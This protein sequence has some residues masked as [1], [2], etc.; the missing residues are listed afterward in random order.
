VVPI[1][2]EFKT[3]ELF[4]ALAAGKPILDI[5]TVTA[6]EL[7]AHWRATGAATA[8]AKADSLWRQVDDFHR[9]AMESGQ[10]VAW[11]IGVT[12]MVR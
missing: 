3:R 2:Y 10:F 11:A 8:S 4:H 1:A 6:D 7:Y 5:E 12:A 9:R